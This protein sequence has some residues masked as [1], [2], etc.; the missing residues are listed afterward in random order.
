MHI[1]HMQ[2]SVQGHIMVCTEQLVQQAAL[3]TTSLP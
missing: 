2:T 3:H 1:N